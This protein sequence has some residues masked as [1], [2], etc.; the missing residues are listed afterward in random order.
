LAGASPLY[1]FDPEDPMAKGHLPAL[2]KLHE[3]AFNRI[4]A[5]PDS[6]SDLP[7]DFSRRSCASMGDGG[8]ACIFARSGRCDAA[9]AGPFGI[10]D[11]LVRLNY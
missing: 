8:V 7:R 9:A 10:N 11:V 3:A 4:I 2:T 6:A 5:P 1:A